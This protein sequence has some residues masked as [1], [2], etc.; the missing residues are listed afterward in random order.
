MRPGTSGEEFAAHWLPRQRRALMVVD[1]VESVRLMQ[2]HEDEVIARWQSFVQHVR[3]HLLPGQGGRMVKSLGDGLLLEFPDRPGA[4]RVA[5]ACQDALA[6]GNLALDSARQMMLRIGIHWADVVVDELDV[7]GAG[8]NLS[9]RLCT[10]AGPGQTIASPEVVEGLLAGVDA[11]ITDLGLQYVKHVEAPLRSF[12]LAAPGQ[13]PG[14]AALRPRPAMG[15]E[16]E[17]NMVVAV[18]PFDR[19]DTSLATPDP[20]GNLL[21]D[22]LIAAW[23]C[24]PL[25]N[26]VSRLSSAALHGRP[27]PAEEMGRLLQADYLLHGSY[28]LRGDDL[29]LGCTLVEVASGAVVHSASASGSAQAI[30]FGGSDQLEELAGE[31]LASMLRNATRRACAAP[32]STLKSYAIL[33]GALA[34]MHS[35][36]PG[37]FMRAHDMLSYL[38]ERH[39]RQASGRAWLGLWHVLRV[40]Q[41]WSQDPQQDAQAARRLVRQALDH[42]ARHG[43]CL[44]VD[45]LVSAYVESDMT[46]AADRYHAAIESN[47]NEGLAWLYLSAV[48]AYQEEG[49]QAVRCALQAQRLSP[50]DPLRYYYD[51]FTSTAMLAAGDLAGAISYGRRSLQRNALHGPTL[52]V[53]AIAHALAGDMAPAREVIERIRSLDPHFSLA[54]FR[55]RYP[56]KGTAQVARYCDALKAAG[57]PP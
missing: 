39:P 49:D 55:E 45:G 15:L 10:L 1:L 12:L 54:R 29:R 43:L 19:R 13:P 41:G 48:H 22:D 16:P 52:R 24:T 14:A 27:L 35:L 4:V 57:V 11:E 40:G 33:L 46:A 25:L 28:A 44:A 17:Q 26:V 51:N 42:D 9:Q 38:V 37:D 2:T 53:L 56:G 32:M 18:M 7:Y 47:P 3:H 8:V 34:S 30:L 50:L 23:S 6:E 31:L 5:H 21:A 36:A 20:V